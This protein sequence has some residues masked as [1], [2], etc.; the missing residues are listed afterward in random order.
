MS[1]TT[2]ETL[3]LTLPIEQRERLRI[4]H[5]RLQGPSTR[6]SRHAVDDDMTL[7]MWAVH[8]LMKI[9]DRIERDLSVVK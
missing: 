4:L 7:N 3:V 1:P 2:K 9:A 8:L 6:H 5:E